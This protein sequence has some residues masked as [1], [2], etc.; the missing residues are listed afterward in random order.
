MAV[1]LTVI[2]SNIKAGWRAAG[3]VGGSLGGGN[4]CLV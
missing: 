4:A 2:G 1:A 3:W